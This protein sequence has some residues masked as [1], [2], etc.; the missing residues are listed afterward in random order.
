MIILLPFLIFIGSTPAFGQEK[1]NEKINLLLQRKDR[2]V[3]FAINDYDEWTGLNNPIDDAKA[4]AEEL[5]I[6][7]G[8]EVEII[9]NPTVDDVFTTLREYAILEYKTYDQ[10]FIFFAGHGKFDNIFNEGFLV[11]KDSK[12]DDQTYN[13]YISHA[14]LR[15]V[16]NSIP[17]MHTLLVIDACFSGT[18][19]PG[20]IR[21]DTYKESSNF[22]F[23]M[24]KLKYKTRK[25]LTSGGN[26]Y[27][28]D[29][30]K[31][32]N[33]P[34]T[35]KF[36]E[37]LR[38]QGGADGILTLS[39]TFQTME[40]VRPAPHLGDFG[41]NQPGSDFLFISAGSDLTPEDS[42]V[43]R[44]IVPSQR[45]LPIH[46][47]VIETGYATN[48]NEGGIFHLNVRYMISPKVLLGIEFGSLW[49][50]YETNYQLLPG[51]GSQS[52]SFS[53]S[54]PYIGLL[55]GYRINISNIILEP[56][57]LF[58]IYNGSTTY[59]A[60]LRLYFLTRKRYSLGLS[61]QFASYVI[62]K[63]SYQFNFYGSINRTT[64]DQRE[65]M[66]L[67]GLNLLIYIR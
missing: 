30:I 32:R 57:G 5:K 15:H 10:L 2:A 23:V 27:V 39:E 18:I 60:Q 41:D 34:F 67:G 16:V 19:D 61:Y 54:D 13:S 12:L 44:E 26:E 33:S 31:G 47:F 51:Y 50:S 4:I 1:D 49:G 48:L 64:T 63:E 53:Y 17:S 8:F 65:N 55:L 6:R 46:R 38:G 11:G 66:H 22:V 21:G 45:G 9:T 37:A 35:S 20:L 25:Y 43:E 36:L 56:A 14:R 28:S 29:G 40:K 62:P 7:F 59:Q 58:G 24:N 52:E 3:L 42:N